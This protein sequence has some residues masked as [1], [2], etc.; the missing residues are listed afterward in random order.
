VIHTSLTFDLETHL[1]GHLKFPNFAVRDT[2][3]LFHNFEPIHVMNGLG[4][5]FD[6]C[7]RGLGEAFWRS[8]DEFNEFIGSWHLS[9]CLDRRSPFYVKCDLIPM[10]RTGAPEAPFGPAPE[11]IENWL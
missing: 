10:S 1:Q 4:S 5:F 8:A 9:V 3:A 11:P 2:P 7:A 6:C